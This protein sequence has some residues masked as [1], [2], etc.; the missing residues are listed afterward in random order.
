M[1]DLCS[2]D[3]DPNLPLW[4]VVQDLY[5]T[6]LDP[7][8][9]LWDVVQDLYSTYLDPI[10]PLWYAVQDLCSTY[11]DPNMPLWDVAQDL[12]STGPTQ[13]VWATVGRADFKAPPPANWWT[14]PLRSGKN[15]PLQD[16]DHL[17]G[18]AILSDV[19]AERVVR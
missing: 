6:D 8:R 13:K 11:I 9:P 19:C 3:V 14:G 5:G 4:D 1:Q 16:L 2:T 18:I 17:V 7:N 10:L 15:L 12:Y